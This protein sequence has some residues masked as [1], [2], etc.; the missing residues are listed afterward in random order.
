MHIY[1]S[2]L[3]SEYTSIKIK[4][5]D[6]CHP[7]IVFVCIIARYILILLVAAVSFNILYSIYVIVISF[8]VQLNSLSLI[9]VC[10]QIKF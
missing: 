9:E 5:L 6:G 1:V 7:L 2:R 10:S 3:A 4:T 8:N